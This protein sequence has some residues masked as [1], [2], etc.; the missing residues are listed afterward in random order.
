MLEKTQDIFSWKIAG[1]M[2]YPHAYR[3]GQLIYLSDSFFILP[4]IHRI[5]PLTTLKISLFHVDNRS[6]SKV[7]LQKI[8]L[9][10]GGLSLLGMQGMLVCCTVL[11]LCW[12]IYQYAL[13]LCSCQTQTLIIL[14]LLTPMFSNIFLNQFFLRFI[15]ISSDFI[16]SYPCPNSSNFSFAYPHKES[17]F[18][19]EGF[20]FSS[21]I[22][23]NFLAA[24]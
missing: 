19:Y 11:Y 10:L 4:G 1:V 2:D 9:L 20:G 16:Q 13:F 23:C 7:Y 8:L 21:I 18:I 5:L 22:A 15:N 14:S 3:I 12:F 6:F 17:G 24:L